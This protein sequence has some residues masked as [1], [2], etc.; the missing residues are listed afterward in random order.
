[1][2]TNLALAFRALVPSEARSYGRVIAINTDGTS[3]VRGP[4]GATYRAIG[5]AYPTDTPV[6]I[7]AGKI[8]GEAPDLPMF[9]IE[10]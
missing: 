9:D 2:S 4:S 6:W 8:D 3:T 10:V 7:V 1:M 5:I